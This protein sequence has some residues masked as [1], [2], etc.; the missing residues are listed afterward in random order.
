MVNL[1][2]PKVFN[3]IKVY[4]PKSWVYDFVANVKHCTFIFLN[5][6]RNSTTVRTIVMCNNR[7]EVKC[8]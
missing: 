6:I 1:S 8:T 3:D 2:T 4:K 7:Q 5:S